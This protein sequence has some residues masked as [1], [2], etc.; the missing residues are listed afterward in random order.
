MTLQ[1]Q[2]R[3][4]GADRAG[5]HD[6]RH[7]LHRPL[8]RLQRLLGAA[9]WTS[10]TLDCD[11]F[12]VETL[13]EHPRRQG[14]AQGPEVPS[15]ERCRIHGESN[16]HAVRDGLRVL[17]DHH[18]G[19]APPA[20]ARDA[21]P[22]AAAPDGGPGRRLI[23]RTQSSSSASTPR[24]AGRTSGEAVE[25]VASAARRPYEIILVVDHNPDLH[26]R[27]KQRVS[28]RDRGGEH[29]RAG[30][31][32]RQEHRRGHRHRRHR[33]LPRRRR[34]RRARLAGGSWRRASRT[35]RH[36]G[37]R[38]D[39]AAVGVGRRPALV[40]A[41]VRL[42]RGLHVSGHAR[43]S[44]RRSATS[45]AGTPPSAG[46]V[47]GEVGGFHTGI[48]RSVQGAQSSPAAG[49][50]GDGVLHPALPA[51]YPARCCCSSR[52]AT[53]G[54]KVPAARATFAYF[55][56]RCY[57]EGLSKALVTRSV[58]NRRRAGERAGAR[59]EGASAGRAARGRGGAQG[60]P[61]RPRQSRGDRRRPGLDDL[62]LCGG[63]GLRLKRGRS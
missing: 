38:A 50:R 45:W 30:A 25:S 54:H 58:G 41:R 51:R 16:L 8:L 40:P 4:Q 10:S 47:V 9:T 19:A 28:R 26:L 32:R 5:Q 6:V 17:Q 56:S 22:A 62:G 23:M 21:R 29:A 34:G 24:N 57:A 39:R 36:G 11:G 18:A 60:R 43:P 31:V 33:R 49:L 46:E 7:P 44:G 52:G 48:G 2:A 20:G 37:G 61:V 14:G 27:L 12:E 63:F 59:P 53:I 3:Q 15:H 1:P 42:D 13:H 55:R 35:R